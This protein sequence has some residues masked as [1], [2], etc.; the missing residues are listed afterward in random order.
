MS[1]ASSI[2][3]SVPKVTNKLAR[4]NNVSAA[5]GIVTSPNN[6]VENIQFILLGIHY[7]RSQC[8]HD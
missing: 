3:K 5:A 4:T 2:L 7:Y 1:M 8:I 6:F